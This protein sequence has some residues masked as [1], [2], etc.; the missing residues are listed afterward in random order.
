MPTSVVD[1]P[2][3]R[4]LRVY[5]FDPSLALRLQTAP[6]Q[7]IT[8]RVPW[9]YDAMTG[10][11]EAGPIG[12]YLEVVDVDPASGVVYPPIGLDDP[13]LLAQ[14]GLR[15]SEGNPQFHQQMVYAVAMAT[16]RQ[17]ELALGRVALW[18]PHRLQPEESPTGKWETQFVR[19]LRIYPHALRDQNAYYSPEKKA[20]LFGYF[21]VRAR[22]AENTPGTTVFLCLSHDVIAHEV[23]HALLDGI[24]PRFNEP[25]NPDVHSFHEA[26]ADI[27]A[28]FS[29][30]S[31]PGVLRD[32]IG[33]TRGDLQSE[34]LLA[35]LAQQFGRA[36]GRGAALRDAL[37]ERVNG[38]WQR[39]KPD[40]RKLETV[41]EPHDRG[42]ILVA[43][44][45]GAFL[46][47]YRARS[48]DL[49]RIASQGTGKLPEGDI[50]PDL[51]NRLADEASRSAQSILQM[52]I[53][54]LDYCP[55]VGITFGD[56]LRAIVTA[57]LNFNPDD[58][59]ARIAI[60]ESFR[61]WG[62]YPRGIRSMSIEALTWPSG[63]EVI[64]D[65][66]AHLQTGTNR[67]AVPSQE[68]VKNARWASEFDIRDL[69][70]QE[71]PGGVDPD[72]PD[73]PQ[74][75]EP[76]RLNKWDLDSDR[77]EVWRHMQRNR[78]VIW[79]WLVRGKG[80]RYSDAFG[81]VIDPANPRKTIYRNT[82]NEPT[83]EIHSVRSALRRDARGSIV[84]DLIVEV[85]QRR[86]GYFDPAEQ[87]QKDGGNAQLTESDRPDFKFRAGCTIVIDTTKGTFRHIIRTPGNVGDDDEL[88]RVR[89][90]LTGDAGAK[91]N[92]FDGVRMRS[93]RDPTLRQLDE[94]FAM[95]HRHV[96]A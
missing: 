10:R 3:F 21:P 5:A 8:I 79:R 74:T 58:E 37:G 89:Q 68:E 14:D 53:R 15:P 18:A 93:L 90:F 83:V 2:S 75:P 92:A 16:V 17:F 56:Y 41:S 46:L 51:A 6:I 82:S 40:P 86:R 54:A 70:E 84:T 49:F 81:L 77:L 78:R 66:Q 31:Y 63:A 76:L 59:F 7:E 28:L 88:E 1:V 30:F 13:N 72:E 36:T 96:E 87:L 91:S 20:L 39:R 38:V 94:P 64:A 9:D 67:R 23:T 62:I 4:R 57:D 48:A 25:S 42:S 80:R 60:V 34:N 73:S 50:H 11:L 27:V 71:Q 45:F 52:C 85:T 55:P 44:V 22:D 32:Q 35:Q 12:E 19:R 47:L 65:A 61:E 69:F 95:L 29:H 43:A 33:R 24:H 26:F